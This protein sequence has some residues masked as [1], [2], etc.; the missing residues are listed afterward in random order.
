MTSENAGRR[1][2]QVFATD[3]K[4]DELLPPTERSVAGRFWTPIGVTRRVVQHLSE[5]GVRR[6]LDVGSGPGKFCIVGAASAPNIEFVGVEQRPHLV[7]VADRLARGLG[8]RNATFR[9]G[10]VTTT[11]WSDFDALYVFNSFA[12]NTFLPC[13]RFDDSVELSSIRFVAEVL[14]VARKLAE[15]P[16][17]TLLLTYH[18]LGGPIPDAYTR[19]S[20]ERV[21]SGWLQVWRHDGCVTDKMFWLEDDAVIHAVTRAELRRFLRTIGQGRIRIMDWGEGSSGSGASTR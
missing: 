8:T 19:L 9:L 18:G 3:A 6:V 12:E 13:D 11:P 7:E 20:V 14:R 16:E 17:G 21:G 1:D 5:R 15:L 10:D 4:F 2:E